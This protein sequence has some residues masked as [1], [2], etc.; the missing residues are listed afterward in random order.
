MEGVSNFCPKNNKTGR[1]VRKEIVLLE[2]GDVFISAAEAARKLGLNR[3]YV[4][5]SA[6]EE[7]KIYNKYTFKYVK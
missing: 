3:T 6:R 2:T 5:V 4:C 7:K 1:K